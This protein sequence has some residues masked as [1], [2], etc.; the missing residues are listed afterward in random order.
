MNRTTTLILSIAMTL[1][2]AAAVAQQAMTVDILVVESAA[3]FKEWLRQKPAPQGPYPQTLK[4]V[5]VGKKVDFPI[6]VSGLRPPDVGVMDLVADVE[7]FAPDGKSV[8]SAPKCCRF[9]IKDLPEIR[10]AMLGGVASLTLEPGDMKGA[11][12]MRVSVTDGV[13]TALGSETFQFAG[14]KPGPLP[15]TAPPPPEAPAVPALQMGT[16]PAK[17][18]GRDVDKRDCLSL[19]TPAEVIKCTEAG[20]RFKK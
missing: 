6:V 17:N 19:P 2:S 7:L 15:A 13:Q 9:T 11:Y 20:T 10:T 18:P 16:P 3:D 4:E 14:G 5:P 8:F 1:A 12:M